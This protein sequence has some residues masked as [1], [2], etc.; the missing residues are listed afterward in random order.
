M[1]S[2]A[3]GAIFGILGLF[4]AIAIWGF[5][6]P[7]GD[8]NMPLIVFAAL[9]PGLGIFALYHLATLELASTANHAA[10]GWVWSVA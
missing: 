6:R 2:G 1:H 5:L 4:M 7:N 9:A 10:L 8:M 3:D